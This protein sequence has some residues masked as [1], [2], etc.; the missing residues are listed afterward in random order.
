MFNMTNN[1]YHIGLTSSFLLFNH[2]SILNTYI[3]LK[4]NTNAL[5]SLLENSI[6]ITV[7]FNL[8]LNNIFPLGASQN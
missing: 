7:L 4:S 1:I 6:N 8:R 2:S 3:L 5:F